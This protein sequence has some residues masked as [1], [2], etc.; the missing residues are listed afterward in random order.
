MGLLR[1]KLRILCTHKTKYAENANYL[2]I[3]S[4]GKVVSQGM[5]IKICE[6]IKLNKIS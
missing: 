2:I 3:L 5:Y 6:C 4:E 1:N